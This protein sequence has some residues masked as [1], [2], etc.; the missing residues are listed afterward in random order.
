MSSAASK[1]DPCPVRPS[2]TSSPRSRPPTPPG[3]ASNRP[4]SRGTPAPSSSRRSAPTSRPTCRL[5]F[6]SRCRV[7]RPRRTASGSSRSP[8]STLETLDGEQVT[9][10]PAGPDDTD[11]HAYKW[12]GCPVAD[13]D[14]HSLRAHVAP[15]EAPD[16]E[17]HV[18]K[19][20][21]PQVQA[22]GV[23]FQR[24]TIT[25]ADGGEA[26]VLEPVG[27]DADGELVYRAV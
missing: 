3:S 9:L 23:T 1:E 16:V 21:G 22:H 11:A 15:V 20:G 26:I 4:P 14:G 12:T 2:L 18:F 17:S 5:S 24:M 8:R 19:H 7:A 13:V 25:P 10:E 6:T 27:P